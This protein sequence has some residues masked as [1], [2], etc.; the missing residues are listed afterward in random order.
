MNKKMIAVLIAGVIAA[1][2][3]VAAVMCFDI[4][5]IPDASSSVATSSTPSI[6]Y[7]TSELYT[8]ADMDAAIALITEQFSNWK[9]AKMKRI[10]FTNDEVCK[11]D[12]EYCNQLRDSEEP[13]FDQAIVFTTD[14]HSPSEKDAEGTTWAPDTDYDGY[15]WHLARNKGG[16]W[17]LLTWGY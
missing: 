15:E 8:R 1:G 9:G 5:M 16:E 7:G 11:E 6:E 4:V 12:V 13:E 3:A 17:Q 14:F 2:C 10:V